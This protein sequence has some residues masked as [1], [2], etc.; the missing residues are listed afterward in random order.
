MVGIELIFY[1]PVQSFEHMTNLS[2]SFHMVRSFETILKTW[3]EILNCSQ[4]ITFKDF[5]L[6]KYHWDVLVP[7]KAKAAHL[8]IAAWSVVP[9]KTNV[10]CS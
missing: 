7:Q 2:P 3:D 5:V 4:P 1:I 9:Y 8:F 6:I 10:T